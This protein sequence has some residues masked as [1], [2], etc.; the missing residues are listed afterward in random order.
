[1]SCC[2]EGQGTDTRFRGSRRTRPQTRST[3]LG[4]GA[5]PASLENTEEGV[6]DQPHAT[7]SGRDWCASSEEYLSEQYVAVIRKTPLE[8]PIRKR[9]RESLYST[10]RDCRLVHPNYQSK[11]PNPDADRR[12]EL[13]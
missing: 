7:R 6:S 10:N 9:R 4:S 5:E 13:L 3:F 1:M 12:E 11:R 8:L 2:M